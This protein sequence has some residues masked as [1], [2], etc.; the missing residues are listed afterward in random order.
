M[1]RQDY[2]RDRFRKIRPG[3]EPSPTLYRRLIATR[4]DA[5]T[6]LLDVGCG[7]AELLRD[8]YERSAHVC[9]VDPDVEALR[10]NRALANR[11]AGLAE[12]L[13]FRDAAF[14]LVAL[15]WVLE[16]LPHPERAFR[17]IHRIL[18]PGGTVVF[19]TPNT[20]NYNVWAI[21]L[22][23]NVFHGYF[24]R[25]LYSR[26]EHGTY[27]TQYKVNS[28]R[29]IHSMLTRVGFRRDEVVFNGDP[30][31]ISLNEPLFRFACLLERLLDVPQLRRARVHIIAA[32]RKEGSAS[33]S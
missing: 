16:H 23:P 32:Y 31:Y 11:V 26:D 18:R 4:V 19:L 28:I 7:H 24:T 13:P 2:W 22:V 8:S 3:W 25:R 17:E 6:R 33:A 5:R 10:E 12:R 15:A 21:R 27:P 20:W 9:G 1:S 29:R 30:T 14:D